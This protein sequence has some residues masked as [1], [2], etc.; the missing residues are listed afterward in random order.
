MLNK[1]YTSTKIQNSISIQMSITMQ[2]SNVVPTHKFERLSC[3]AVLEAGVDKNKDGQIHCT[4]H[5]PAR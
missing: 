5:V 2:F 3:W 4:H 1:F